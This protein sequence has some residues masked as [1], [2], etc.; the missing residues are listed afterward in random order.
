MTNP[1]SPYPEVPEAHASDLVARKVTDH[2]IGCACLRCY[3]VRAG[4]D[5][6]A[7]SGRAQA[8]AYI[9]AH[10]ELWKDSP[11]V[12]HHSLEVLRT[13]ARLAEGTTDA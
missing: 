12:S 13:A 3:D 1:S 8:A 4:F 7:A 6:G 11:N 5:I 2:G 10:V 9:R